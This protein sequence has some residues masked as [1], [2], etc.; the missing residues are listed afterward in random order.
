MPA[1]VLGT[2]YSSSSILGFLTEATVLYSGITR[3]VREKLADVGSK[4]PLVADRFRFNLSL[5]L[6][7]LQT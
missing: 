7:S 4:L 3:R 1:S 6:G 2:H 5:H